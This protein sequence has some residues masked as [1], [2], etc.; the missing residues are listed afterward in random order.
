MASF[1]EEAD[2]RRLE[3][4][5]AADRPL[6]LGRRAREQQLAVGQHQ[7]AVGVALGLADVVGRVDDGRALGGEAG[8]EAPQP[9]ALAWVQRG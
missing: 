7:H 4:G 2:E 9:L 5:G 1:V 6:E 3:I 8:D